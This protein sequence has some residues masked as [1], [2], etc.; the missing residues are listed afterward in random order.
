MW[1]QHTLN[2]TS[3]FTSYYLKEFNLSLPY[4]ELKF[5]R[6]TFKILLLLNKDLIR[7]NHNWRYI[8]KIGHQNPPKMSSLVSMLSHHIAIESF[9][10]EKTL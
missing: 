6:Q 10:H 2:Q 4:G 8:K 3:H 7:K 1:R 9:T 5:E